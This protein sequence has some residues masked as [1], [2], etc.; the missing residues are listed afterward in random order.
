M[1]GDG[2]GGDRF[3]PVPVLLQSG[4]FA[5][6]EDTRFRH[7]QDLDR[8]GLRQLAQS[9]SRIAV[10]TESRRDAVL[11]Q[12]DAIYDNTARPPEPLRMPYF[13]DCYRARP[14]ELANYRR[15]LDAPIAPHL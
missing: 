3:D 11:E 5:L 7:W 6:V 8:N 10:L 12:V 15:T 1:Q 2:I 13:T 4:L 9:H 14:S